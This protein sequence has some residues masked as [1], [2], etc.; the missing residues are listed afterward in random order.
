MTGPGATLVLTDPLRRRLAALAADPIERAGVLLVGLAQ[1]GQHLRLLARE[2]WEPPPGAYTERHVDGLELTSSGWAPALARAEEIGAAALFVHNHP[3]GTPTPSDHDIVVDALL[4]EPFRIRSGT[5]AFGSLI[6]SPGRAVVPIAFTG[7]ISLSAAPAMP[8]TRLITLG[9]R[10]VLSIAFDADQEGGED[11]GAVPALYSRHVRAFGG[12]VQRVLG[13]LRI[14]VAGAGGTGSAVL[15]Q[16]VRLGIRDIY[17]ADPKN[18]T[19]SNITRVYG[20]ALADQ[21]RPKVEIQRDRLLAIAPD[22]RVKIAQAG[23]TSKEVCEA[24]TGCDVVFGCTDDE[25]GRLLLTRIAAHY[26]VLL[27]DCGVLLSSTQGLLEGIDGRVTT[28]V[29]GAAC[30]IC[31]HR[32]DMARA[33][34]ELLSAQELAD[35]Q[36]EGYAPE[37]TGIEPAVISYTTLTAALAV[38]ELL[39]RLVGF[40]H[41]PAPTEVIARLHDRELSTNTRL[42]NVGH[43]CHPEAGQLGDGDQQPFLGWTWPQDQP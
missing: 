37:L 28:Q 14:G 16:L 13:K 41:D 34:A 8:I 5:D 36:A 42:P 2:L 11:A 39:E 24:L 25:A 17:L 3:G 12:D 4:S 15:E 19:E 7:L 32:I 29:P 27:V 31:R 40:G 43:F 1:H 18:L 26:L 33:N 38:N 22:L 9:R 35:R 30:L 21:G 10:L 6:V 20:S 23:T